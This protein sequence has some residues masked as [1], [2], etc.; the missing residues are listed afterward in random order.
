MVNGVT[1]IIECSIRIL[2]GNTVG[3]CNKKEEEMCITYQKCR[4]LEKK[5]ENGCYIELPSISIIEDIKISYLTLNFSS[6]AWW[7]D[8]FWSTPSFL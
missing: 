7:I 4:D 8:R 2:E 5:I 6:L 1:N 3:R